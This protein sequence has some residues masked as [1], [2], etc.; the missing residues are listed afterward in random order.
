MPLFDYE[1]EHRFT[2]HEHDCVLQCQNGWVDR[3]RAKDQ[4]FLDDASEA[5]ASNP[6]FWV[7]LDDPASTTSSFWRQ[8]PRLQ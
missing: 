7:I 1:H 4:P 2:E 3:G 5:S 8:A 6:L